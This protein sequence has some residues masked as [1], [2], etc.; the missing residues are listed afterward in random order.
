M[1][2]L[3][4]EILGENHLL[5]RIEEFLRSAFVAFLSL[6]ILMHLAKR[7]SSFPSPLRALFSGCAM[8]SEARQVCLH[9][10]MSFYSSKCAFLWHRSSSMLSFVVLGFN[11]FG[12]LHLFLPP[13]A[14]SFLKRTKNSI[15]TLPK[16]ASPICGEYGDI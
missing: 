9:I 11:K 8:I 1:L 5:K 12:P 7:V 4:M 16:R 10:W 13:L 2:C 6:D 3:K 15:K 14:L